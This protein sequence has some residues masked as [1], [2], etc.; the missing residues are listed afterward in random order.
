MRRILVDRS[1]RKA[2]DKRQAGELKPSL[3][4][5]E[6]MVPEPGNH[7]LLIHDSLTRLEQIDPIA[8]RVV[9]LKFFSGLGSDEIGRMLGCS[10]RSVERQWTVAKAR[11]YQ[12]ICEDGA[13]REE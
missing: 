4:I 8:A 10:V 11:L 13:H 1:R 12:M 5:N 6:L 3:G 7:I 2:A 9:L